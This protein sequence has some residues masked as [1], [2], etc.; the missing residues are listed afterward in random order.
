MLLDAV[1]TTKGYVAS[2]MEV[3]HIES[4]LLCTLLKKGCCHNT[5]WGAHTHV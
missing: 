2:S 5:F 4:A 1:A 3:V